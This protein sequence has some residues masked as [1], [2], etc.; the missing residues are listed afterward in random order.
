MKVNPNQLEIDFSIPARASLTVAEV[1]EL[2]K[3]SS[4]KIRRAIQTWELTAIDIA[5]PDATR[6]EWRIPLQNYI[7]W[8]N[9][10]QCQDLLYKFPTRDWLTLPRTARFLNCSIQHVHDLVRINEFPCAVNIAAK[11][12]KKCWRLARKDLIDFTR[13]RTPGAIV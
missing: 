11:E 6:E 7:N 12:K 13:R 1:A 5:S 3:I 2:M 10:Q 9:N 4:A 8:L